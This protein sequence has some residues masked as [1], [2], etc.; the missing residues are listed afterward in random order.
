MTE[1]LALKRLCDNPPRLTLTKASFIRGLLA[2]IASAISSLPVLLSPVISTEALVGA[3]RKRFPAHPSA[4]RSVRR[5]SQNGIY[6]P[7]RSGSTAISASSSAHSVPEPYGS[8]SATPGCSRAWSQ[9]RKRR[10][11]SP[12]Q[13]AKWNPRRSLRLPEHP[14]EISLLVLIAVFLL[15]PS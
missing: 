2:W 5:S 3:M 11:A 7:H 13:P 8:T 15:L 9:N 14:A 10:P 6:C 1:H 4:H 12:A